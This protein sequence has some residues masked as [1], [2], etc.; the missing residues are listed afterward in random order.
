MPLDR[1][2]GFCPSL[3]EQS[4]PRFVPSPSIVLY[5]SLFLRHVSDPFPEA[6]NSKGLRAVKV[7]DPT[8]WKLVPI[9]IKASAAVI[10]DRPQF[11]RS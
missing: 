10:F 3:V 4:C 1:A 11:D 6:Q 8:V 7:A 2:K 9:I 5:Q